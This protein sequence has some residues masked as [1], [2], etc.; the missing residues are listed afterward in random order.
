M[1]NQSQPTG[2]QKV[3][4]STGKDVPGLMQRRREDQMAGEML[5]Q[6]MCSVC[7]P[8]MPAWLSNDM[9]TKRGEMIPSTFSPSKI[10]RK[11]KASLCGKMP[12]ALA[13]ALLSEASC[14]Q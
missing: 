14:H 10:E 12:P 2:F 8:T 7:K 1:G 4:V 5:P 6:C 11:E 13:S 3:E 9:V